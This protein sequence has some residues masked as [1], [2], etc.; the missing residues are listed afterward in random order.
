MITQKDIAKKLDLSRATV[1][2]ILGGGE[3][4]KKFRPE[5][6]ERVL[7]TAREMEYAHND[8]ACSLRTGRSNVIGF[9]SQ[10]IGNEYS[11]QLL[12]GIEKDETDFFV[13][14]ISI[15]HE[16]DEKVILDICLRQFLSGIILYDEEDRSFVERLSRCLSKEGI[17]LVMACGDINLEN[18][19]RV[20]SDVLQAG[21]LAFEHLYSL[22][23]RNM[24][25]LHHCW[26]LE[27]EMLMLDGFRKAAKL[28]GIE[29][30]V[31]NIWTYGEHF[32]PQDVY[33][34]FLETFPHPDALFC[35]TV[36]QAI[37]IMNY[38][39][40]Q[41]VRIPDDLSIITRGNM[42]FSLSCYPRLTVLDETLSLIGKKS[43]NIL[44]ER[45]MRNS[46]DPYLEYVPHE[47]IVRESTG[48]IRKKKGK[49]P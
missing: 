38:F 1:S 45:I 28:G 5:I 32:S 30:P 22:G 10:S 4:A 49:L 44:K 29:V 25:F 31:R 46:L 8:L 20:L 13:K 34:T 23:H 27:P 33:K 19:I 41:G 3:A 42:K 18:G 39:Q 15:R 24:A 7:N 16:H 6:R 40:I 37:G 26:N 47:L 36:F 43:M 21:Q 9:I 2:T 17:P 35:S 14:V 12:S 48:K 11:A